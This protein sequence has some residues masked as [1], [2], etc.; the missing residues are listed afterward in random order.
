MKVIN[1]SLLPVLFLLTACMEFKP[2][3]VYDIEPE[4]DDTQQ[5]K[6]FF[7]ETLGLLW[8]NL[9]GCAEFNIV[10]EDGNNVILLDWNKVNC[11]WVGFGNSWSSFVSDDISEYINTSAISFRVKAVEAEQKS[12]PFVI[13]LED[14]GGGNSY[15]FSE[16]KD[17]ANRLSITTD[18]W[19]TIN[20]PLSRYNFTYQGVDPTNI[21]QMIIQLEGAGKVYL[22]DIKLVPFSDQD[23]TQ[24]LADV[25]DM[26]PRGNPNQTIYPSNFQELAWNIGSNDCHSLMEKD[27]QIHWQWNSCKFYNRW[28]FNWHNW[29]AFNLRGIVQH[30]ALQIELSSDFSP[31]KIILEDYTGKSSELA[32]KDYIIEN[33]NDSVSTLN[34]PLSDFELIE[35]QFVLDRMKQFQFVGNENG[36]SMVIYEMKLVKQ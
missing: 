12:I 23:Y 28:G 2:I 15:V 35:K 32:A 29:Y 31:F 8:L 34:I 16:F 10:K 9:N 5:E 18:Q 14:Y 27:S 17:F 25:E 4:Q 7:D 30:T 21:K 24:M 36:G 13:G 6:V 22:D 33:Q 20:I 3:A 1:L 19:T 11:D 26:R